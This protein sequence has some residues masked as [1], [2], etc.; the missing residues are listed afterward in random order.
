MTKIVDIIAPSGGFS[1]G[2]LPKI[3]TFL[4]AHGCI[5]RIPE[6]ILGEDLLSANGETVRFELL[7]QALYSEDSDL[8]WAVRGG[9]GVTP[10]LSHLKELPVPQKKKVL[11]GFSDITA[12]HI[13][14]TQ[15]WGWQTIHGASLRQLVET[16]AL[17]ANS[18]TANT[19]ILSGPIKVEHKLKP[20]N[21]LAKNVSIAG[22]FTGGNLKLVEAS[23]GTFWQLEAKDKILL[24]EE[25][26]EWDYRVARSLVHLEQAG[27]F[28]QVQAV[29]LG[30]FSY[31]EHPGYEV[32]LDM[33]LEAFAKAQKIPIF[34]ADFF[35]HLQENYPWVYGPGHIEQEVL[36]Q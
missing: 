35:G 22:V 2:V 31:E 34:R 13:F 9:Y 14:L 33:V 4:A 17:Q 30:Q 26:S 7:K 21:T 1:A 5:A 11:V 29:V 36:K 25:V 23:L 32:K 24:L 16:N 12:L 19:Q 27:V 3:R 20:L 18:H 10:L 8:I 15:K 28:K 6:T